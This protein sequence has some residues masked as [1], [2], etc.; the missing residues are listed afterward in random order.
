MQHDRAVLAHLSTYLDTPH[1][2]DG[3]VEQTELA[4]LIR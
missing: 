1:D 4:T 3:L 2:P